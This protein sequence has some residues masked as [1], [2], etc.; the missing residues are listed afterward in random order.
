MKR[1]KKQE[2]ITINYNCGGW[3]RKKNFYFIAYS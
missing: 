2:R 1:Y 3:W